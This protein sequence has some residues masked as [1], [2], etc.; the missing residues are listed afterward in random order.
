[1]ASVLE[2]YTTEEPHSVVRFLWAKGPNAKK[3][4]IYKEMFPVYGGKC[5]S[6]KI[7]HNW[8]EKF[9][10]GYSKVAPDQVRKWLRQQS[11]DFYAVEFDAFVKRWNKY[12]DVGGG[13]VEKLTFFHV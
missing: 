9:S 5:L 1:M 7:V 13:F 8:V 2:E 12:I 4:N 3:K 11:N 6:R 10:Q